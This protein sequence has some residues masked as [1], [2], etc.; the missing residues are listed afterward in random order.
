MAP[1]IG[2]RNL[3]ES[4]SRRDRREKELKKKRRAKA[5]VSVVVATSILG[6]IGFFAYNNLQSRVSTAETQNFLKSEARPTKATV[7][8][9]ED[10]FSGPL[11]IL[12]IGS[13]E[14][15]EKD[16]SDT[17]GMRSD[18]VM[19]AH[20]SA[21]RERVELVSIPR[22]S[23]VTVPSCELPN[24]N[25]TEPRIG[26][27]NAAFALGGQTGDTGAAVACTITTVEDLTGV[28]IDDY[29][30]IDFSGFEGM[31]DALGG[32]EFNVEEEIIDPSFGNTHIKQGLQTFDG[33]TALRYARVRKAQGMDGS[34]I[35][36]IGRQ[37]ELLSA[38]IQKAM[39]KTTDPAA[40]YN[41]VGSGLDMITTSETLGNL[42][43]MAGFAWS[44]KD[45][46]KENIVFKT[47]PVADRGDGSNVVW[48]SE[49]DFL[50]ESI[51]N[52]D[53]IE[54]KAFDENGGEILPEDDT[55][56]QSSEPST[57]P[58]TGSRSNE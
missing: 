47:V 19:L 6:G 49:A 3:R 33:K 24:G 42:N 17:V 15:D 12:L 34:D 11:N 25:F 50:W 30:I 31:V 32:V 51:Q 56:K 43:T 57:S 18:T 16:D 13:D 39:K 36:R 35:S 10:P 9:P 29:V 45:I 52:D 8:N 2:Q 44:M 4:I 48:T 21:D 46:D 41:L 54:G 22:D 7:P 1:N 28:F 53:P 5:A 38:I 23:W 40:M 55:V 26:K 14:R 58:S 20:V 27:F 37:Q